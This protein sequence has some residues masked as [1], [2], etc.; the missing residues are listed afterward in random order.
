MI[1]KATGL[2]DYFLT[3]NK[4]YIAVIKL[5]VVTDTWDLSG[6]ILGTG[7][8]KG[9]DQRKVLAVLKKFR[10]EI[11]QVPPVYS[12]VKYKGK[13]SYIYARKG[14]HIDLKPRKVNVYNI[15]L[16]SLEDSLLTLKINCSSGTYIRSIAYEIGKALDVG[17][18]VKEL[19]RVSI[20]GYKLENSTGIERF[21]EKEITDNEL[22]SGSY[23]IPIKRILGE[24]RNLYIKDEFKSNILCG[25]PVTGRMLEIKKIGNTGSLKKYNFVNVMD[26]DENLL[27][28]HR[29]LSNKVPADVNDKNIILTKSIIVL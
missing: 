15:E 6:K 29:V 8:V 20:N 21:L 28:V 26:N 12:S 3:L 24:N 2:F 18:S 27:A 5:G 23:I 1:N 4:E 14:Q 9:L 17:A 13:P 22:D 19:K 7:E 11:K 16:I 10:G 25:R